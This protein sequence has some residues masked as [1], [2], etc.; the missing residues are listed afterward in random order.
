MKF[1]ITSKTIQCTVRTLTFGGEMSL[2]WTHVI[3]VAAAVIEFVQQPSLIHLHLVG[4]THLPIEKRVNHAG[5]TD[6]PD[7]GKSSTRALRRGIASN[8]STSSAV[9]ILHLTP[10]APQGLRSNN[11]EI[12]DPHYAIQWLLDGLSTMVGSRLPDFEHRTIG[13][14]PRRNANINGQGSQGAFQS[15]SEF[16]ELGLPTLNTQGRRIPECVETGEVSE[17]DSR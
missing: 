11:L 5:P 13:S 8:T 9:A 14:F 6:G 1:H 15:V 3:P 12:H 16:M 2:S 4:L 10:P 7:P 17:W